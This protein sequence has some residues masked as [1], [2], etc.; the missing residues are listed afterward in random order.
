MALKNKSLRK[1]TQYF[2]ETEYPN[3]IIQDNYRSIKNCLK[4]FNAKKN[5]YS[6]IFLVISIFLL[7]NNPVVDWLASKIHIDFIKFIEIKTVATIVDQRT[8][9][10]A[11]IISMTL[12]VM[13]MLFSN[14]AVKEPFLYELL[15]E[16]SLLNFIIIYT[17]TTIGCL[18]F[19]GTLRE[20]FTDHEHYY[21][22]AILIGSYLV[23]SI[24]VGIAHLFRTVYYFINTKNVQ[25]LLE[26]GLILE[27]K[28]NIY[29]ELFKRHSSL[30]YKKI[31]QAE[32]LVQ[33]TNHN[34]F[35]AG[36]SQQVITQFSAEIN[37][38]NSL[39]I[40]DV[41]LENLK[42]FVEKTVSYPNRFYQEI[43]LNSIAKIHDDVILIEK[44][45]LTARKKFGYY[46]EIF[47]F[48][49]AK[50]L[51]P[52]DNRYYDYFEK[53]YYEAVEDKKHKEVKKILDV[54][55]KLNDLKRIYNIK[56]SVL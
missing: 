9:N 24:L 21:Y 5:W 14:M 30:I 34:M 41:N 54:F 37:D 52:V 36:V 39:L 19:L 6:V 40:Y 25:D 1:Q 44:V 20:T 18:I 3:L 56:E 33:F 55:E 11:T 43:Q 2:L 53:K 28:K 50:D 35:R 10:I 38:R 8:S 27:S 42:T 17:L 7:F 47:I 32:G 15:Y 23:M 29:D 16:R 12:A 51:K 45:P 13:A 4:Y 48:K 31:I 49:P 22:N 46:T 26:N